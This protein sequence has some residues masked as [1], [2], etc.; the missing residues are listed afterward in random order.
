M[1][2]LPIS[3]RADTLVPPYLLPCRSGQ[4]DRSGN[5]R[6]CDNKRGFAAV[7]GVPALAGKM[8]PLHGGS[9]L[10]EIHDETASDRLK[11]GLHTLCPSFAC[12]ICGLVVVKAAGNLSSP[13][14]NCPDV[15]ERLHIRK[16]VGDV[17]QS[18]RQRTADR[19][20]T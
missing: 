8:L 10:L 11:P 14:S 4:R 13:R 19:K 2:A 17:G 1:C 9:K 20:S 5:R 15:F 7:Y 12:E 18:N 3:E 16:S 6:R